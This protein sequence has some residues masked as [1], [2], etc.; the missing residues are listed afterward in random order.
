MGRLL[1]LMGH[2][3]RRSQS[4]TPLSPNT[5][6]K[7]SNTQNRSLINNKNNH[8]SRRDNLDANQIRQPI[9]RA[10]SEPLLTVSTTQTNE[11]SEKKL[12]SETQPSKSGLTYP[13]FTNPHP[14]KEETILVS[15]NVN[16]VD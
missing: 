14:N 16:Y 10:H 3:I 8:I 13:L 11:L 6:G 15:F 2:L 7:S 4:V 12:T 9:S 5:A 1:S